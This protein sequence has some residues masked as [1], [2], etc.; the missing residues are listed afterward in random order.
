M[1][2]GMNQISRQIDKIESN[3]KL[4]ESQKKEK[5][6]KIT[7]KYEKNLR[8]YD[9]ILTQYGTVDAAAM[10]GRYAQTAGKAVVAAVTVETIVLSVEKLYGALSNVLAS[11]EIHSDL[12]ASHDHTLH[13]Q[14]KVGLVSSH[15]HF[16]INKDAIAHKGDSVERLLQKQ[17]L[18]AK[19]AHLEALKH[20][21]YADGKSAV[22]HEGDVVKYD[23]GN[24]SIGKPDASGNTPVLEGKYAGP[25]HD[26]TVHHEPSIHNEIPENTTDSKSFVNENRINFD[27]GHHFDAENAKHITETLNHQ[28]AST[29]IHG[30]KF[31]ERSDGVLVHTEKSMTIEVFP[32]KHVEFYDTHGKLLGTH[33]KLT[34]EDIYRTRIS[35][36][37]GQAAVDNTKH[38]AVTPDYFNQDHYKHLPDTLKA[39]ISHIYGGYDG[40]HGLVVWENVRH[41]KAEDVLGSDKSRDTA[42]GVAKDHIKVLKRF[43]EEVTHKRFEPKKSF[44]GGKENLEHYMERGLKLLSQKGK[45]GDFET[46]IRNNK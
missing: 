20:G 2:F 36:S 29:S 11:H 38:T 46:S 22:V 35:T 39:D 19:E 27:N 16:E 13:D 5:V 10:A 3:Q 24:I 8:D 31:I 25:M 45:L 1:Q 15:E 18:S 4:S 43:C 7:R 17:G 6:E 37:I 33:P 30:T 14:T 28:E 12:V 40:H 44:F 9:R 42:V 23:H 32:D 34:A 21:L 26:Y 41:L